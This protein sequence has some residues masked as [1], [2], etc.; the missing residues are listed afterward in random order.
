[1]MNFFGKIVWLVFFAFTRTVINGQGNIKDTMVQHQ[2]VKPHYL[3]PAVDIFGVNVIINRFDTHIMKVDWSSVSLSFWKLNLERGFLTDG[4]QFP[5]NWLG[6]P[7]HGS[8][9][10]NAARMNHMS[11]WQSLPYVAGGSLMWEFFGETEP[12]SSID[13]YT[14]TLGGLYLG[15]VTYRLTDYAWNYPSDNF[16][17][18]IGKIAGSLLNPV[19]GINR[20]VFGKKIPFTKSSLTP[21]YY[22]FYIGTNHPLD[23]MIADMKGTGLIINAEINYGDLFNRNQKVFG[24]FDYF[25][26]NTWVNFSDYPGGDNETYFNFS[27]EAIILGSK[28]TNR[29]NK[30]E[31]ISLTQHYDFIH[32]D[33]FKIGSIVLTGDWTYQQTFSNVRLMSSS[34]LGVV[35]FG[36]GNSELV[37][38]V[39]P[40]VFPEFERDYIYGQG[41]MA[42]LEFIANFRKFGTFAT[43]LNHFIIYSRSQPKGIENMDLIRA[44]Y[45]YP[46]GNRFD[47]GLQ[48]DYYHRNGNYYNSKGI[49]RNQSG[50]QEL[51]L[52]FGYTL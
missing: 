9:F 41:F 18:I 13:L 38:P 42:E 27:S 5:T 23:K 26:I 31:M 46:I 50:H 14:T 37:E 40:D 30:T 32:N 45:L 7:I 34:K 44:K 20:F 11:F 15:E 6:H 19:A 29:S 33:I 36:S 17:P 43:N 4:D 35:L 39:L 28:I 12:A 21:V 51:K 25:K 24:P 52:L 49:I 1:M 10:F 8:L 3:R 2:N 48:F 16:N 47:L 22:Q